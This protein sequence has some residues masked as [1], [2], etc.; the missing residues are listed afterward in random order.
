MQHGRMIEDQTPELPSTLYGQSKL[1]FHRHLLNLKQS[2]GLSAAIDW[3]FY[4]YGPFEH[5]SKLVATACHAIALNKKAQF[6]PLDLWRDYLHVDDLAR[7][8]MTLLD[9][10]HEGV[11]NIGSGQPVRQSTLLEIVARLSGRDDLFEIGARP[12]NPQEPPV[13]FADTKIIRSLG[14]S[15]EI[16]LEDGLAATLQWWRAQNRQAA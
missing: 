13:L 9:S 3:I 1:D 2:H 6:G 5:Q 16:A 15:P 10:M 4:V 12:A 7:A 8:I 14:W 11:V